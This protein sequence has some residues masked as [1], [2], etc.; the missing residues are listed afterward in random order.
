MKASKKSMNKEW[1]E[2]H[3]M[4]GNANLEQRIAWHIAHSKHCGCREMPP[5]IWE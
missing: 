4:P 2:K 3:K 1:H 5:K